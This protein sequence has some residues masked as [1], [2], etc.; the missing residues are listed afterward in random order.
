MAYK[1]RASGAIVLRGS[2]DD[3]EVLVIHRPRPDLNDWSLPKGGIEDGEPEPVAAVREVLE[4]T[5]YRI[6]LIAHLQPTRHIVKERTKVVNW[7]L[8]ELV[9]D[10]QLAHDDEADRVEWWPIGRALAQ[11]TYATDLSVLTEAVR[12]RANGGD[13]RVPLL[14]VRHGK[15]MPRRQFKGD[16]DTQRPLA[17]RGERQATAL[18]DLLSAF[19]VTR[20]A[21]SSLK[22]CMDTFAP[23][24]QAKGLTIH[25]FDELAEEP[26]SEDPQAAAQA[27]RQIRQDAVRSGE[28]TAVCGHR[29]VL[30]LMIDA[31]TLTVDHSLETAEAIYLSV[32]SDGRPSQ[33]TFL[34]PEI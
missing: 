14:I 5:G 32:D 19:G 1:Y 28:P 4:E 22:R 23:Y 18:I 30:P 17:K 26:A 3:T 9:D 15:A 16:D 21:S 10:Q 12:L 2:G 8:G 11:L 7:W 33:P 6:R 13:Q 34:P 20:L 27:M 31:L 25:A 24:A 29:P